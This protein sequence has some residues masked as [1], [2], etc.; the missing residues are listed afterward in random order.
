MQNILETHPRCLEGNGGR[1]CN[2]WF[3]LILF[4][5]LFVT[6]D[7]D[8]DHYDDCDF[9]DVVKKNPTMLLN[10]I[11]PKGQKKNEKKKNQITIWDA[12]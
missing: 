10:L 7:D 2:V 1:M 8:D 6:T 9:Q 11:C 5:F 4:L 12:Y 3:V